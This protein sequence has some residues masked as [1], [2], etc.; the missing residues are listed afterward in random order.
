MA[1][2][3]V[4]PSG[5]PEIPVYKHVAIATGSKTIYVA[6][7]VSWD[8]DGVTIGEGDLVTQV[9]TCYLNAGRALAEVGASFDD[10]VRLTVYA[11]DWTADKMPLFL[12]G[13]ARASKKLGTTPMAPGTLIGVATL[14]IP[15]HLVEVEV[16][17]VID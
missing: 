7:Q 10:V 16:T 6:G 5:L 3:L 12:E 8:A 11:V 14:D 1:I 13:L 15:D 9:E 2:T 17:A 4:N